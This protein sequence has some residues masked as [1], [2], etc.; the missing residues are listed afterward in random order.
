MMRVRVHGAC[1]RLR[2]KKRRFDWSL[3]FTGAPPEPA[4]ATAAMSTQAM[5]VTALVL[6]I[7]ASTIAARMLGCGVDCMHS[8]TG[9]A[10]CSNSVHELPRFCLAK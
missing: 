5:L 9:C 3:N 7:T 1:A 4:L 2:I 8:L 6:A 10:F